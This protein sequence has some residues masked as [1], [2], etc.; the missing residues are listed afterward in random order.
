MK[1]KKTLILVCLG[2]YL[3]T[4]APV[5]AAPFVYE[6]DFDFPGG[7]TDLNDGSTMIGSNHDVSVI[8]W[9]PSNDLW[10]ALWLTSN[11]Q[12][13]MGNFFLPDL[14]PTVAVN[15]FSAS[16]DL[17]F[18]TNGSTIY[19]DGMSFN[20]GQFNTLSAGYGGEGGMYSPGNTGDVLSISWHTYWLGDERLEVRMNGV[21]VA[22]S[23]LVPPI[24]DFNDPAP[25]SAF[26]PVSVSWGAE[27]LDL[28]Y[29]NTPIFTNLA[30][31]GFEPEAGYTFAFSARTGA[32]S[33]N[34]F[35]DNLMIVAV[36]E[37]ATL[38]LALLVGLAALIGLRRR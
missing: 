5:W 32:D 18:N 19:A 24:I 36:P 3:S 35:V 13:V 34:V 28:T 8:E 21:T 4:T 1:L 25:S 6:Q 26:I 17:M 12:G 10:R 30:I 38:V 9:G 27:G 16:F 31:P 2:V 23:T 29:N 14:S 20:F 7:T 33:Q 37:P 11:S 22:S 15:G